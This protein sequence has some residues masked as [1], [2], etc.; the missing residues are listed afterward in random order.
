M[1]RIP[2]DVLR[3]GAYVGA[4]VVNNVTLNGEA[5]AVSAD[6]EK[7]IGGKYIIDIAPPVVYIVYIRNQGEQP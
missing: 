1:K 7:Q 3:C 6:Q 2:E 4:R 5:G